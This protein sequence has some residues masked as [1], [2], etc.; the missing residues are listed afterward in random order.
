MSMEQQHLK[1]ELPAEETWRR[2]GAEEGELTV[3]EEHME[4]AQSEA[5]V[6]LATVLRHD[7]RRRLASLLLLPLLPFASQGVL[8]RL[9]SEDALIHLCSNPVYVLTAALA[10]IGVPLALLRP[11]RKARRAASQLSKLDDAG[12][13]GGLLETLSFGHDRELDAPAQ[14]ALIRALSRLKASDAHL[15]TQ[16]QAGLLRGTLAS[17]PYTTGNLF[18]SLSR[19]RD[20]HVRLQIAILKAFEQVGDSQSLPVVSHLAKSAADARI[21]KAAEECLPFVEARVELERASQ[22]LLRASSEARPDPDTLLRPAHGESENAP[23]ALLRSGAEPIR[24]I[25]AN[26]VSSGQAWSGVSECL[27]FNT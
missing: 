16:R 25:E 23:E 19:R 11:S 2:A 20:A 17:S 4:H 24:E 13:I 12:T 22:T 21:R 7:T 26:P 1:Q 15:I 14:E 6:Q 5:A 8:A 27:A 9:L 10:G 18:T 3:A